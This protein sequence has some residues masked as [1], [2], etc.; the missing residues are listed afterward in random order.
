MK[1]SPEGIRLNIVNVE[2]HNLPGDIEVP[3]RSCPK[4]EKNHGRSRKYCEAHA[5]LVESKG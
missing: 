3:S 5:E 4:K 1:A 2:E